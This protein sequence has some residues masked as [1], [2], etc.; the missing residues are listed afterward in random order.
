M[1]S[2]AY[3]VKLLKKEDVAEGTASFFF[4]K[5]EGFSY[6]AGQYINL[7][8]IN[9]PE[10][11][12]E[13]TRRFFSLTSA[14]YEAHLRIATRMRDT[15]FK[16]ILKNMEAGS[17]IELFGPYGKLV[18]HE[19]SS[20]PAV[21]L[22]GGIGVT[23]FR[24]MVSQATHDKSPQ[25]IYMFYSNRRPEDTVFLKELLAW[26]EENPNFKLIG[27]MTD[28][29]NSSQS[30]EGEQGV[31]NPEMIKKYIEDI[32]KPIFYIA[33]PPGMVEAMN[34]MLLENGIPE[35]KINKEDFTGY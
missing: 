27:T 17:K 11:D 1:A 3:I 8:L 26:Q 10:T 15:A 28:M 22:T 4:E 29:A 19:D 6:I 23:P 32:G 14:P 18:L 20:V 7:R 33:G 35:E 30:W 25:K 24:S 31:I 2:P 21:F 9:P 5:P 34:K 16:R 13:G 12:D